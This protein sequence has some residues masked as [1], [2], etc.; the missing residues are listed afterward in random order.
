MQESSIDVRINQISNDR[1]GDFI[2]DRREDTIQDIVKDYMEDGYDME[3]LLNKY[4][5]TKEELKDIIID[6]VPNEYWRD[7]IA[8]N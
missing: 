3:A 1:K 6:E 4:N 7:D 5:M 8:G 2:M